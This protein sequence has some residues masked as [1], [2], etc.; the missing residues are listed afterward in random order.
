MFVQKLELELELELGVDG[1]I[2]LRIHFKRRSVEIWTGLWD[3]KQRS[4]RD[5]T[6]AVLHFP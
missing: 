3:Q 2:R 4:N 1:R 6:L 5:K